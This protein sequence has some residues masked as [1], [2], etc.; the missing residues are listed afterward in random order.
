[1]AD[2]LKDLYHSLEDKYY[3]FVDK[4]HLGKIVDP[5]DRHVPS[6]ALVIILAFLL[7]AGG[8][9]ALVGGLAPE[10]AQLTLNVVDE[11]S[12]ALPNIPVQLTVNGQSYVLTTDALGRVEKVF[13]KG[14]VIEIAIEAEGFETFTEPVTLNESLVKT[15][16]LV[17]LKPDS[18]TKTIRLYN[19]VGQPITETATLTFSCKNSYATPPNPITTSTGI[20]TVTVPSNCNGLVVSVKVQ[21]FQDVDSLEVNEDTKSIYLDEDETPN[22][23]V[24]VVVKDQE[25]QLVDG[26]NVD[27]LQYG[28]PYEQKKTGANG[29]VVFQ[30]KAGDYTVNVYDDQGIYGN[31]LEDISVSA[32]ENKQLTI[33]V[34]KNIEG[35]IKVQVLEKDS[36]K[37]LDKATV[38]LKNEQ[39]QIL[40]TIET[41]ASKDAIVELF[42]SD[43]TKSYIV[44]ASKTGYLAVQK[45]FTASDALKILELE[46]FTGTNA[47]TLKV[48][49]RDQDEDPVPN[50][51]VV[52]YDADSDF[53]APYP[54][55]L[56]DINGTASFPGVQNGNYKAFAFKESLSAYSEPQFFDI[57]NAAETV[58]K[59]QLQ[60]PD[61]VVVVNVVDKDNA[62]V[63]FAKVSVYNAFDE[64]LLGA[65]LTDSN[66]QYVLPSNNQK[67]KADK[68]VFV[69]VDK[70]GSTLAPYVSVIK[71]IVPLSTQTFTV[72]LL[73]KLIQGDI[74]VD[75]LGLYVG[76][77]IAKTVGKN[78][79]YTGKW[80]VRIPQGKAFDE[81]SLH[82]RTGTKSIVEKDPLFIQSVN[83]AKASILKGSSWDPNNGLGIDGESVTNDEAKWVEVTWKKPLDG[84]YEVEAKIRV[85]DTASV[86]DV[87]RVNY[88]V[89]GEK[90]DGSIERDPA[91]TSVTEELY[92]NT[93]EENYQLGV[94]TL[95]DIEFCF[96]ASILD[97][98]N[99]ILNDLVQAYNADVFKDYKLTFNLINNGSA[100]HDHAELRIRS[101]NDSILFTHYKI[102]NAESGSLEADINESE[103]P[104]L[105]VGNFSPNKKVSGTLFF[106][107]KSAGNSIVNFL[108]VSDFKQVF[109]KDIEF[110]ISAANNLDVQI[111]PSS[112]PSGVPL[113][114]KFKVSDAATHLEL[115]DAVVSLVDKHG[116]VL[117][118][119]KTNA[120]GELELILPGQLPG[121]EITVKV[122]SPSYNTFTQT[123]KVSDKVLE[124]NPEK[125]GVSINVKTE[126]EVEDSLEVTNKLSFALELSQVNVSGNF[127]GLL[128]EEKMN[129][130]LHAFEG[131]ILQP[132]ETLK[133][134][135]KTIPTVLGRQLLDHASLE[136]E[137]G[138]TAKNFGQEWAFA[139]PIAFSL[140]VSSEVDDPGCFNLS[141]NKWET[142]TEG[143]DVTLEFKIQ[144]N[145]SVKDNPVGLK[146]V[147]V[148]AV[149]NSNEIGDLKLLATSADKPEIKAGTLVKSGFSSLLV[150]SLAPLEALDAKLVFTPTGGSA[151]LADFKVVFESVNPLDTKDQVLTDFIEAK[152]G[153]VNLFDCISY[154]KE[155]LQMNRGAS[156]KFT[157]QTKDCGKDVEFTLKSDLDLSATELTL[158]ASD[159]KEVEVLAGTNTELGQYPITVSVK[160]AEIK[161]AFKEKVLRARVFDPG[162]CIQLN[163]YEFDI[164]DDPKIGT[165]GVDT[166]ELSNFCHFKVIEAEFD[167]RSWWESI[168]TGL[169]AAVIVG[170]LNAIANIAT[171]GIN[172]AGNPI[173]EEAVKGGTLTGVQTVA[174]SV[175]GGQGKEGAIKTGA[176]LG[177]GAP[178]QSTAKG[179]GVL[180]ADGSPIGTIGTDNSIANADGVVFATYNEDGEVFHSTTG[181]YIG[182][183]NYDKTKGQLVFTSGEKPKGFW[184]GAWDTLFGGGDEEEPPAAPEPIPFLNERLDSGYKT[185]FNG[186]SVVLRI[187]DDGSGDVFDIDSGSII[188]TFGSDELIMLKDQ[189]A[190]AYQINGDGSISKI[191]EKSKGTPAVVLGQA[192]L[193]GSLVG[194]VPSVLGLITGSK[195]PIIN[196][197]VAGV[198]TTLVDYYSQDESETI[199]LKVV[200]VEIKDVKLLETSTSTKKD[201]DVE[202]NVEGKPALEPKI[203]NTSENPVESEIHGLTFKNKS[204]FEGIKYKVVKATGVQHQYDEKGYEE[205]PMVEDLE[206]EDETSVQANFHVQFNSIDPTQ[207]LGDVIPPIAL[208]CDTFS[209]KTGATG[210]LVLPK[211][212]FD[213]TFS[214]VG[215]RACDET[216]KDAQ[217]KDAFIY[218]D[219]TQF[220][221]ELL[222][223]VHVL[224]QFIELNAPFECP[225]QGVLAGF[226]SQQ[227]PQD[228]IGIE[229]IH[230]DKEGKDLNAVIVIKNNAPAKN[231]SQL[232]VTVISLDSN[233]I[234][235][236]TKT[237]DVP[238][239]SNKA[240]V[241]CAFTALDDGAYSLKASIAPQECEA[242]YNSSK[243]SDSIS[244]LFVIG[245]A[246]LLKQ[247]APFTTE[248]LKDFVNATKDAGNPIALPSGISSEEEIFD[249][250]NFNAYL[251][252]DRY[253]PDFYQDFDRFA[254]TKSFFDAPPYY[255]DEK[256]GLHNYFSNPN[257]W[258]VSR[259]FGDPPTT[260]YLLPGGG[261]YSAT[262]DINFEDQDML[263]YKSDTPVAKVNVKLEKSATED[264]PSPFYS[265]PFNGLIGTDD[266]QGRVGYGVNFEGEKVSLNQDA[267]QLVETIEIPGSTPVAT[268]KASKENA[269]KVLNS[270]ERGN[271]LTIS[272]TS[273]GASLKFAPSFATP[274][275]MKTTNKTFQGEAWGFYSVGI[276][277]DTSQSYLGAAGNPW[278]GVG[279]NCKAFDDKPV[280]DTFNGKY[281]VSGLNTACAVVGQQSNIAYG[282]EWCGK[283]NNVNTGS[284]YLK[285]IFYTP[286][287]SLSSI[288]KTAFR[289]DMEFVGKTLAGSTLPLNGVDT[290][291]LNSPTNTIQSIEDILD[292]VAENHVCVS[293]TGSKV[294]FFWNPKEVLN[295]LEDQELAAEKACI[296]IKS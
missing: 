268:V 118:S 101:N 52:L 6:F 178:G 203:K 184:A 119:R 182:K 22:A 206:E 279:I 56:T 78:Q 150:E 285:S 44:S 187:S 247:C 108:L 185:T 229:S 167:P 125:L 241:G 276:N 123:L 149:W 84:V 225:V 256:T 96:D 291:P 214:G 112:Y 147:R 26:I 40:T 13:P 278:W 250:V 293:G 79:E 218:C 227:I 177:P 64:S 61:G 24:T 132:N 274:V 190:P 134:S 205:E 257:L 264:I 260:G 73:P 57:E 201:V 58:Y 191:P 251:I 152:I 233:A 92:A 255:L 254:K 130:W 54:E 226:E 148:K 252:Q 194:I 172:W 153:V 164:F 207:I 31:V 212:K 280:Q 77:K 180:N 245:Q 89:R 86:E 23:S 81:T 121:T 9:L 2:A 117:E 248:R 232:T 282:F 242:C 168:K 139:V 60:I 289:E 93:K 27:L 127:E 262:I 263:F 156:D 200:D 192:G 219:A 99:G 109:S 174:E 234:K 7:I 158:K 157:I 32:S 287:E 165:D 163:R 159:S 284:V 116:I 48:E 258:V 67:S 14:R 290:V 128:D 295:A 55:Q 170:G 72:K 10:Q 28:I 65:D 220:S 39:G 176:G 217:G 197:L 231:K 70:Q 183:V 53:L 68:S 35:S 138:V 186:D 19:S 25:N 115:K 50:A 15:L 29:T 216:T 46:K 215:M 223:K 283:T 36:K 41:Q 120:L 76:D 145:C 85:R 59:I 16:Q 271:V 294:E 17:A 272:K 47:G 106:K 202:L 83:V 204:R 198:V 208:A 1:M 12:S 95:C 240:S 45:T 66:G 111:T 261:L 137:L 171:P 155:L 90:N 105:N 129:N 286:Q 88:K 237:V 91:D 100:V 30:V 21:G 135:V 277:N 43:K 222:Q 275:I 160:G 11:D 141:T 281:D 162:A 34:E 87:M 209:A 175:E 296:Q 143:K 179:L 238:T 20:A 146:N 126:S 253:A 142:G 140:G 266:G 69:I 181:E 37:P 75:F 124:F 169:I 224:Q 33:G 102:F 42:V 166:A 230:A 228:D 236:C 49:V 63:A 243:A 80:Q 104:A 221:I 51:K 188:G 82:V 136:G 110:S 265:L 273:G 38:R 3:D 292:L 244:T 154:S 239:G 246:G 133:M 161:Q 288:N 249:L 71:P 4:F 195:N 98:K 5:I 113:N 213:W 122:E 269:F 103:L 8:I 144:N 97:V 199:E 189:P 173:E 193:G 267:D 74:K 259:K 62:P 131:K 107:T 211:I 94:T 235:T 18:N 151:G 196:G 114:L 210:P 270:L